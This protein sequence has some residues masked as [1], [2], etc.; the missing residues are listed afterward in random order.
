MRKVFWQVIKSFLNTH[1]LF[2][3]A[4]V[5]I[6]LS[7]SLS[8]THTHKHTHLHF[9]CFFLIHHFHKLRSSYLSNGIAFFLHF[10]FT[11]VVFLLFCS[12]FQCYRF[13]LHPFPFQYFFPFRIIIIKE[14][15]PKKCI[16]L[17]P[18][19][20]SSICLTFFF[21]LANIWPPTSK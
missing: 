21:P 17:T 18:L 14:C 9:F 4:Y 13:F 5:S 8:H 1:Q 11:I 19:S 12:I 7:S 20:L 10:F 6:F 16:F 2:S 15:W 3:P